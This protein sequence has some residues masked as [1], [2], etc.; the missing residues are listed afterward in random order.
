VSLRT[1]SLRD[2]VKKPVHDFSANIHRPTRVLECIEEEIHRGHV[3]RVGHWRV[4]DRS[5]VR[6]SRGIVSPCI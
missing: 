4:N 1:T 2:V 5:Y 3:V 6:V